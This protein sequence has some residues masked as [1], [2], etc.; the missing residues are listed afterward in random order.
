Q[1]DE[2]F[3]AS[4]EGLLLL[5]S[6][7]GEGRPRGLPEHI[8]SSLPRGTYREWARPGETE[9]RCPIC[10]ED[11]QPADPVLKVT[12][13]SHWFHYECLEVFP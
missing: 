13:C 3:D 11:Y 8:I 1:R 6:F 2:D 4:Y 9:E 5:T 7:I 10:L 12:E